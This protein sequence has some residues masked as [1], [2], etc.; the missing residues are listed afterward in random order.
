VFGKNANLININCSGGIF[1]FA[2]S[3]TGSVAQNGYSGNNGRY[4]L[5]Y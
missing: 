2:G 5:N 3:T 4:F 1:G